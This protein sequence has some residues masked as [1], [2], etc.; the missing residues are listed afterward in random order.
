M[1]DST[2]PEKAEIDRIIG[3][4]Q[5]TLDELGVHGWYI[6]ADKGI[7]RIQNIPLKIEEVKINE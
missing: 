3:A 2:V 4:L 6:E 1:I 5:K 7:I